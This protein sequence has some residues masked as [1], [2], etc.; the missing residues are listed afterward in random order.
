MN[1]TGKRRMIAGILSFEA[2]IWHPTANPNVRAMPTK[3]WDALIAWAT[4]CAQQPGGPRGAWAPSHVRSAGQI[5][6]RQED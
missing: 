3:I 4:A 2:M 5:R 6:P 1:P